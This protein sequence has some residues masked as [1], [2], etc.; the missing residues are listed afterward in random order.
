MVY[1][2]FYAPFLYKDTQFICPSLM[3][4]NLFE[5]IFFNS[6]HKSI[7]IISNP[8]YQSKGQYLN[9]G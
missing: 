4:E 3:A 5:S 9:F 2:D 1:L 8:P 7:N 6:M